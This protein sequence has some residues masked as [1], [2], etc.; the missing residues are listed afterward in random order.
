MRARAR[1]YVCVCVCV[2]VC[3]CVSVCQ[4]VF[5]W[6]QVQAKKYMHVCDWALFAGGDLCGRE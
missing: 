4:R 6:A 2:C 3:L 5:H 1:V